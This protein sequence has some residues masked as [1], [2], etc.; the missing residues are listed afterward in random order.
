MVY[1][2]KTNNSDKDMREI[3]G[4]EYLTDENAV[5]TGKQSVVPTAGLTHTLGGKDNVNQLTPQ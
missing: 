3:A 2:R 5:P 1:P 4:E